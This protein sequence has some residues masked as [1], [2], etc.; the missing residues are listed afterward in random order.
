M[1]SPPTRPEPGGKKIVYYFA[2]LV[3]VVSFIALL[4]EAASLIHQVV[5]YAIAAPL[6]VTSCMVVQTFMP[7][8]QRRRFASHIPR[9]YRH[10]KCR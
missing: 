6:L 4:S 7:E 1:D 5:I 3:A 8:S 2:L 9:D 10:P